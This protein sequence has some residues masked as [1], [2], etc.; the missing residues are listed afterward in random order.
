MG[1]AQCVGKGAEFP[2]E[3]VGGRGPGGKMSMGVQ[4]KQLSSRDE[5]TDRPGEMRSKGQE[6]LKARQE[7]VGG[8]ERWLGRPGQY[9]VRC[10]D[11]TLQQARS[12]EEMMTCSFAVGAA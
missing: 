10:A 5:W 11:M 7:H 2:A 4:E 6:A 3:L 8:A 9:W 12:T 1:P